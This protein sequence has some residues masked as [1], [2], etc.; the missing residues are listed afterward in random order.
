H[1]PPL[2]T[3]ES[4]CPCSLFLLIRSFGSLTVAEFSSRLSPGER[5]RTL[6]E[7]EQGKLRLL[8]STDATAR[9]I[10]VKGV[11]CVINY[12]APQFIRTYIHRVGRTA[13]AGK[14]GLA[15]TMLLK[16]Q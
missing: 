11:T 16:V 3:W 12:D 5:K 10:D 4:F 9:G 7:F 6:K 1:G 2:L 15:F 8:I 13:R 14:A